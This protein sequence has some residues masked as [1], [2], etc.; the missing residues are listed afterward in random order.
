V[1]VNQRQTP[2]HPPFQSL[3]VFAFDGEAVVE[4]A[5][6]AQVEDLGHVIVDAVQFI[7]K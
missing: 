7:K 4:I 3:G 5:N 6:D 2:S 1:L